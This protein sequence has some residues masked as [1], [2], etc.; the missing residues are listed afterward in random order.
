MYG[1]NKVGIELQMSVGEY[2]KIKVKSMVMKNLVYLA[3]LLIGIYLG[4]SFLK[5]FERTY[6][7][8][9]DDV[10]VKINQIIFLFQIMHKF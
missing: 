8:L 5:R 1:K 6:S 10:V 9:T 7:A 3:V 2:R 4:M